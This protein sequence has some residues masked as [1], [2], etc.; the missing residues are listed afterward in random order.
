MEKK[1]VL[2][3]NYK[4]YYHGG[5]TAWTVCCGRFLRYATQRQCKLY[6]THLLKLYGFIEAMLKL[7][8]TPLRKRKTDRQREM[9]RKKERKKI[10]QW[11]FLKHTI[12]LNTVQHSFGSING[13]DRH[14]HRHR[15]YI[16][17][18]QTLHVFVMWNNTQS[19]SNA[20]YIKLIR[21]KMCNY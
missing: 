3:S 14:R 18:Y 17:Q 19:I 5:K 10:V 8:N 15:Q 4:L 16:R 11:N 13:A 6:T 12:Q 2:C 20:T 21:E 9:N 1:N 7:P